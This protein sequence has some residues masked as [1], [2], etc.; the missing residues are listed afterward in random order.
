MQIMQKLILSTNNF[1]VAT[2]WG[3]HWG[4]KLHL[5]LCD[6]NFKRKESNPIWV[7]QWNLLTLWW[8]IG[9]VLTVNLFMAYMSLPL[10]GLESLDLVLWNRTTREKV[11]FTCFNLDEIVKIEAIQVFELFSVSIKE[12]KSLNY[13]KGS[14]H[15]K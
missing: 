10:L 1:A 15:L 11:V 12:G 5:I 2:N 4:E 14:W 9:C 3:V 13:D 7:S 8:N 6:F